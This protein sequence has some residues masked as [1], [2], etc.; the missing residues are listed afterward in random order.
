MKLAFVLLL[1]GFAK[2][3][4][5][6]NRS[7]LFVFDK[8]LTTCTM[9]STEFCKVPLLLSN[10]IDPN[11]VRLRTHQD[12]KYFRIIKLEYC[13]ERQI[14]LLDPFDCDNET[15]DWYNQTS[16]EQ[17]YT[18]AFVIIDAIVVG[19]GNITISS[20]SYGNNESLHMHTILV[21]GPNRFIDQFYKVYVA[22]FQVLMSIFMGLLI[23]LKIIFKMIRIP[24]P[25]LI[26]L[27]CQYGCMPLVIQKKISVFC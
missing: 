11:D 27:V 26:G 8:P 6:T 24:I 16:P 5:E 14:R 2:S 12:K 13:D 9:Y 15:L 18:R 25:V 23:D 20:Q 17:D 19:K 4:D 3:N 7:E 22:V 1:I 21:A 10:H